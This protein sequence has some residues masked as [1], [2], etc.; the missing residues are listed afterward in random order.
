MVR[1]RA[2]FLG[3][4]HFAASARVFQHDDHGVFRLVRRKI[5]GEPR[6]VR[7]VTAGL[8]RARLS[9]NGDLFV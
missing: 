9:G 4:G 7:T 3:A 5:A 6:M 2:D 1:A 8:G